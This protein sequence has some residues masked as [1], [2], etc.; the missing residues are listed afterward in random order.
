MSAPA[1]APRERRVRLR[2]PSTVTPPANVPPAVAEVLRSPGPGE[3]IAPT[4]RE[5]R[6]A[7]ERGNCD[8]AWS[9]WGSIH[10][11]DER[12]AAALADGPVLASCP[13]PIASGQ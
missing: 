12:Y 7:V 5:L 11:R 1:V 3:P 9:T 8:A 10:S 6:A 2:R 13:R 4:L